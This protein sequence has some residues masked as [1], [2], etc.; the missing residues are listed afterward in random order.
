MGLKKLWL[1][2][3]FSNVPFLFISRFRHAAVRSILGGKKR[4]NGHKPSSADSN[5]PR[6]MGLVD[7]AKTL[8]DETTNVPITGRRNKYSK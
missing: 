6:L 7:K 3:I 2:S 1:Y 8:Q 4:V 5:N